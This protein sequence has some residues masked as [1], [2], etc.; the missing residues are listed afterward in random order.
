MLQKLGLKAE[1]KTLI[2]APTFYPSSIECFPKNFPEDLNQYN[3]LSH[4]CNNAS[5][6]VIL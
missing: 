3:I 5:K 1:K 2:Y 4:K 6:Y